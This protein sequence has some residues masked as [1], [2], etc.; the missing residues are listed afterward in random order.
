MTVDHFLPR[1]RYQHLLHEWS[2]LYYSCN[3]CNCHYKKDH[4]TAKEEAAGN[5]FVDPCRE[6]PDDH[7]R[8]VRCPET[9]QLCC[10][11]ALTDAGRFALRILK[12]HA[13]KHLRDYWR[14]LELVEQ[15]ERDNLRSIDFSITELNIT[16]NRCK[17]RAEVENV[18][19]R[20]AAQRAAATD[21]LDEILSHRPFPAEL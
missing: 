4:P 20:L 17:A 11:K 12:L 15:R 13:R 5:R 16:I 2:N 6:D 8:L 18:L 19:K 10:I 14:E 1:N 21:R 7:F 9:K 3:T